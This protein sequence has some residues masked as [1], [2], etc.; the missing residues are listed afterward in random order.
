MRENGLF[1][2]L[3]VAPVALAGVVASRIPLRMAEPMF[4]VLLAAAIGRDD[5]MGWL[6][7]SYDGEGEI[8]FHDSDKYL[9]VVNEVSQWL[10][11]MKMKVKQTPRYRIDVL[12]CNGVGR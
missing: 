7:A 3:E 8:G 6:T 4:P 5:G 1:L 12:Y 11:S 9:V 2:L 10:S